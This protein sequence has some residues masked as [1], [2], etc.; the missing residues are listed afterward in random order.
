VRPLAGIRV[1]DMTGIVVGPIATRALADWG[2]DVITVESPGGDPLRHAGVARHRGMGAI[3][4]NLKR[5][6][7]SVVL[8]L[9][10]PEGLAR[11]PP[12][13]PR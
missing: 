2:A 4:L 5:G 9:A 3:V 6:K 11:S 10:R 1:I 13:W 7:R 12:G 8:D